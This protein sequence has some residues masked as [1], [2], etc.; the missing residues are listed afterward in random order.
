ML[1]VR[2]WRVLLN[3][4]RLCVDLVHDV[5]SRSMAKLTLAHR[6]RRA[7]ACEAISQE[8]TE[9]ATMSTMSRVKQASKRKRTTKAAAVE[10][11]LG[12]AGLSFSLV[13]SAAA[14][15]V[16]Q[17][18]AIRQYLAQSALRS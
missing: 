11:V 6:F 12:V 1:Y 5:F 4:K 10:K 8:L 2:R 13:N 9:D 17:H 16:F 3:Q 18:P 15:T 7:H 14:S